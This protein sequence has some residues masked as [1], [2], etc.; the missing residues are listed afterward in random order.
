MEDIFAIGLII[1]TIVV[2]II[3]TTLKDNTDNTDS[4]TPPCFTEDEE[5]E[6]IEEMM[7][8]PVSQPL[9]KKSEQKSF[10]SPLTMEEVQISETVQE[11]YQITSI[12]E[13][14]KAIIWGEILQRK[15]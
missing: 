12:E 3:K 4:Q 8:E 6:V 11:D 15:Y 5:K 13:A 14:R 10:I 1:I 7:Y 2:K 9:R